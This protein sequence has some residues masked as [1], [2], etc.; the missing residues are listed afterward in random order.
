M[1]FLE[2]TRIGR[3]ELCGGRFHLSAGIDVPE[4]CPGCGSRHWLYG[5][6]SIESVRIRT[7]MTFATRKLDGRRDRRES[8]GSGAKSLKR[9]ER[10]RRQ[11]QS[12]K[13]KAVDGQAAS[14]DN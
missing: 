8:E 1:I 2:L 14:N 9:R 13:P 7:G 5:K 11:Y 4:R 6:E 10:A 12:L 3:C